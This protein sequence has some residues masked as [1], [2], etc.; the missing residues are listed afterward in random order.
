MVRTERC[1]RTARGRGAVMFRLL[2]TAAFAIATT[3]RDGRA[4]DDAAVAE[5]RAG[6]VR[7]VEF[8]RAHAGCE[9]GY[10]FRVSADL[11]RREGERPLAPREAWIEPPA[12]PAVG[13]ALLDAH[14]LTGAEPLLDAAVETGML[15]VRG[16]LESGGWGQFVALDPGA[17]RDV[18][19]RVDGGPVGKRQNV[20]TFDDDKT[21]S[22]VRFL[23]TLSAALG[24][25]GPRARET[26]AI[27]GA[28]ETALEAIAAAQQPAGS[29]PQRWRGAHPEGRAPAAA[30]RASIPTDWPREW[31]A[32]DYSD[33][34]TLNDGLM[35]DMLRTLLLARDVTGDDRWERI[36]RRGGDFLLAAQLPE[37]QPG[38]AQ[39]YDATL[40]PAW[41]R[42]FEPPAVSGGE[43][44]GV[45]AALVD[46]ARRTGDARYLE[47]VPRTIAWLSR[48]RLPDG[49]LAR[50]Y[51]LGTNRPLYLTRKYTLTHADDDL[52]THYGFQVK[53]RLD[54]LAKALAEA[55]GPA[56][57]P[58]PL[59]RAWP[60]ERPGP[61]TA[62]KLAPRVREIIAA[63][64]SRGAW[65]EK[66]GLSSED[67]PNAPDG[68][69]SS[70]TFIKNI[71]TL[72][73]YLAATR[74]TE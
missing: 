68:V 52:P 46:L 42:K 17:R 25:A 73:E 6:L 53:S 3:P 58:R 28:A 11:A 9:G 30:A 21:Q 8:F 45:V 5:A 18:A 63:L 27:R 54:R 41:A 15:L 49:R 34:A 60:P 62:K 13:Q 36:A 38:W 1:S 72:A 31:P 55:G 56:G 4:R 33:L 10:G 32:A 24:P 40:R 44:Q 20:T 64:D 74:A 65:V 29:W 67:R 59:P 19:Y 39:Q 7:A 12:T 50:F 22:C 35:A 23:V 47:P 66:G 16:Q 37:P 14:L 26:A 61:G 57:P 48:S 69:I 43:S 2:I 51:E 70:A 71:G